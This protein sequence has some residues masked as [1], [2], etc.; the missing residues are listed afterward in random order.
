[1]ERAPSILDSLC[2]DCQT[3]FR[4]VQES[5]DGLDIP[6]VVDPRLV[7]GLDYYTRTTFEIQTGSLGAQS[8][9]AGGGRYD[10]LVKA[11]GGP[12][13]P[14]TGF[15]IGLDRLAEVTALNSADYS[16]K[17]DLFI[18]ALGDESQAKAFHWICQFGPLGLKAEMD[19]GNK[20][21]KSQ[22]KRANRM[23]AKHVL[24]VGDNELQSGSAILRNMS[25]KEQMDIPLEGLVMALK[26]KLKE[27]PIV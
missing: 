2:P 24:I 1:M 14:A 7:R 26:D 21:L 11:L 17:P 12:Q 10:G 23:D 27:N 8:A 13:Q 9:I 15:A 16:I 20:S 19:Y 18:A 5:L 3:D 4:T 6:Y 25:T 22:M